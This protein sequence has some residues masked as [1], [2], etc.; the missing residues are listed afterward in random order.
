MFP[1]PSLNAGSGIALPVGKGKHVSR[2]LY[3]KVMINE[4]SRCRV[5]F[6]VRK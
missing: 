3:L 1:F 6:G 5:G 2:S 4:A